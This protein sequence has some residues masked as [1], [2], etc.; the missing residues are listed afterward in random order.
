MRA[1]LLKRSC[2]TGKEFLHA[3]SEKMACHL[4]SISLPTRP[5]SLVLKVE[6]EL[7][8]LKA[9]AASSSL[10][11]Q[12]MCD[13]LKGIIYLYECIEELFCLPSNQNGL[14]HPQQNKWVEEE[15]EGSVKLLDLCGTMRDNLGAMKMHIQDLQSALRREGASAIERKFQAYIRFTKKANKDVKKQM[16]DKC[17]Y[18]SQNKSDNDLFIVVRLLT[19]AREITISLLQSVLSFLSKKMVKPKTSKWSLVSKALS[20]RKVACE[21]EQE[22]DD[23]FIFASFSCKDLNDEKVV[24]A[25]KQLQIFKLSI[26]GLENGL[27][28]LFRQLI[29]SRVSLLNTLSL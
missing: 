20:K 7:Q 27:E 18:I 15:L 6:E 22:D 23:I 11:A 17:G 4:R 14:S 28:C 26:G 2:H 1:H 9:C 10:T 12:M 19:E 29:R 5:N 8:K 24:R 13:A 16:G 25:Q 3:Y 21:E